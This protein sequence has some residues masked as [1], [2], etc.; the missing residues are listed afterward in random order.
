VNGINLKAGKTLNLTI[1]RSLLL[2]A[3]EVIQ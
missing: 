1:P 3:N 2:R